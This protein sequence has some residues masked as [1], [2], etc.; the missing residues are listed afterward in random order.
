M[1]IERGRI[2]IARALK[3]QYD[4]FGYPGLFAAYNVGPARYQAYRASGRAL[5]PETQAYLAKVT[6][7]RLAPS[8]V[9]PQRSPSALFVVRRTSGEAVA[10]SSS[11]PTDSGP[12]RLFAVRVSR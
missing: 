11:H 6:D 12:D 4:R 3:L 5:P 7:Q 2:A 1:R 9:L 8:Q 10:P